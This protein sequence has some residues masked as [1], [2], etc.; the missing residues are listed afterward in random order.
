MHVDWQLRMRPQ[1][2]A[3][4][5]TDREIWNVMIVHYI[6]MNQIGTGGSNCIDLVTKP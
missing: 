3:Y 6:E 1:S 5:R 2:F 4:E